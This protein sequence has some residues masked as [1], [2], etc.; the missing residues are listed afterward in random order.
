MGLSKT[1]VGF[2]MN[3]CIPEDFKHE[4]R[5]LSKNTKQEHVISG[6]FYPTSGPTERSQEF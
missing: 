6:N 2:E 3:M 5:H 1:R 4:T